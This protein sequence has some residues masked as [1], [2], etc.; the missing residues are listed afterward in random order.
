MELTSPA[1]K[2]RTIAPFVIAPAVLI[3]GFFGI[4]AVIHN[5][6][7]ESTDNAQ[8][9]TNATPV[10][11]RLAGFIDSVSVRDY[12]GVVNGQLLISIDD[13]EYV[14]A[15]MQAETDLANARADLANAQAQ[16]NNSHANEQVTLSNED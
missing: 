10:V 7:F 6:D 9:E 16:L 11:S 5:L 4:S 14:L 13:R 8:I 1:P 15:V 2:K 3:A 12:D